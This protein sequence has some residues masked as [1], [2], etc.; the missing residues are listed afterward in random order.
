[1][2]GSVGD[3]ICHIVLQGKSL[4]ELAICSLYVPIKVNLSPLIA[5]VYYHPSAPSKPPEN[6]SLVEIAETSFSLQWEEPPGCSWNGI[7]VRYMV[8]I[9]PFAPSRQRLHFSDF[10]N[11]L[12]SNSVVTSTGD[13]LGAQ[14]MQREI[15]I[16]G[17][18]ADIGDLQPRTVYSITVAAATSEGLG[19]FST[20]LIA[21]TLES[22]T[23]EHGCGCL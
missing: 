17:N 20:P 11:S 12:T 14:L 18:Y 8:R 15:S 5:R 13:Q 16:P 2:A 19:P 1:M 10:I 7:I 4:F 21:S 3:I 6:M 22:G 23:H 9:I